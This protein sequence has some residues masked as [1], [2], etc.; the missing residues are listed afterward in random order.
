MFLVLMSSVLLATAT[1]GRSNN[2]GYTFFSM[3]FNFISILF[4]KIDHLLMLGVLGKIK[5]G[6]QSASSYLETAKDIADLVSK[7]LR[8]KDS[9][10]VRK[11]DAKVNSLPKAMGLDMFISWFFRLLGLDSQKVAAMAVNSVLYLAQ[12]VF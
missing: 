7:S 12:M 8:H 10:K 11:S 3:N 1:T 9:S 2:G 6:L 5:A 4:L